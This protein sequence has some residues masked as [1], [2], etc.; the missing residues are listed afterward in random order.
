LS[1]S[2]ELVNQV[3]AECRH[4]EYPERAGCSGPAIEEFRKTVRQKVGVDL[5]EG[6]CNILRLTNGLWYNGL[7]VFGTSAFLDRHEDYK[8]W[9]GYTSLIVYA[10]DELDSYVYDTKTNLYCRIDSPDPS[11]VRSSFKTF[12]EMM[13]RALSVALGITDRAGNPVDAKA[14]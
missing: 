2:L 12:D 4:A 5:P 10:I 14:P 7:G 3:I 6:Y 11:D 9:S 1:R 13:T 8:T